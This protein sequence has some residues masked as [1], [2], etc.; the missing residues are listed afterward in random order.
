MKGNKHIQSFNEH[1]E[2]LNISDVNDSEIT[3][4]NK[5]S[6]DDKIKY[7]VDNFGMEK[8]EALEICPDG[9]TKVSDLPKEIKSYF[10]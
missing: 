6:H 1:Q 4:F 5:L 10:K 7:L 8:V 2:N 9:K 3:K